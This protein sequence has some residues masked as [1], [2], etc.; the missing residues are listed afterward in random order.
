MEAH[1]KSFADFRTNINLRQVKTLLVY[2]KNDNLVKKFT[3][4]IK[5]FANIQT[6]RKWRVDKKIYSFVNGKGN[7]LG[8]IWF[9]NKP[10]LKK[11][12]FS[13][14]VRIY[15]PAR[16]GGFAKDFMKWAFW[17][18]KKTKLFRKSKYKGFWLSTRKDNL[19]AIN[20]YT[21]FGF[22]HLKTESDKMIMIYED[23]LAI[24][25]R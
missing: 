2:S 14:A 20:L 7:L 15:P 22:E 25:D 9:S 18:F 4:D 8:I 17:K 19:Q 24:K 12:P 10:K 13:F 1:R 23:K 3:D 16:G 6:F 11:F 5:R 21:R